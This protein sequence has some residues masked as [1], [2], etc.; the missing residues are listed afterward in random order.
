MEYQNFFAITALMIFSGNISAVNAQNSEEFSWILQNPIES[1]DHL[2]Q[3]ESADLEAELIYLFN[4]LNE[5]D[6]LE[7]SCA[8]TTSNGSYFKNYC[9]PIFIEN[10]IK[11]NRKNW[12]NGN[13]KL[14]NIAELYNS[15]KIKV[16]KINAEF[17]LL[18]ASND[19]FVTILDEIQ[20]IRE[21]AI[22]FN[23]K[24]NGDSSNEKK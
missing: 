2:I 8:K 22:M 21:F 18:K 7:V 14:K 4:Q 16:D 10:A 23:K 19:R 1:K 13:E 17:N 6:E 24:I 15:E 20:T 5:I 3:E 12:R 9:H 11:M